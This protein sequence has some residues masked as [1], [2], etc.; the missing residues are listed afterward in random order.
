MYHCFTGQGVNITYKLANMQRNYL[1]LLFKRDRMQ[2]D[3]S[4][5]INW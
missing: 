4:Y 3:L 2:M 5:S 1:Q